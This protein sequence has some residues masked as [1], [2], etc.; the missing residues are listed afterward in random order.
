MEADPVCPRKAMNRSLIVYFSQSGTTARVAGAIAA[1]LEAEGD[2]ANIHNLTG[3]APPEPDGY[4]VL[5]V[6]LPTYYYRP[7]FRVV[8]YLR[9][10]PCL[11]GL[12]AFVFVVYGRPI[13]GTPAIVCGGLCCGRERGTPAISEPSGL[14]TTLPTSRGGISSHLTAPPPPSFREPK[15]SADAWRRGWQQ[16]DSS[17]N[18]ST[19]QLRSS[20]VSNASW[21]TSGPPRTCI[22]GCSA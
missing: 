16:G 9:G 15:D 4:D 1:G 19:P 7:P 6:G 2:Q 8:E 10:L 5:G 11:R 17:V 13:P 14:T 21:R 18:R 20:T 12:P 3:G 22:V